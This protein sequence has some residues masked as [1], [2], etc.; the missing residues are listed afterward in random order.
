MLVPNRRKSVIFLGLFVII[1]AIGAT[2]GPKKE[3]VNMIEVSFSESELDN[4]GESI[5]SQE[6]DDLVGLSGDGVEDLI[7]EV[8]NVRL[9]ELDLDKLG[10]LLEELQFEDL[11][12]LNED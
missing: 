6:F 12:G 3:P 1:I 11:G 5:E 8:P 9:T 7:E 10:E 2:R 4:L